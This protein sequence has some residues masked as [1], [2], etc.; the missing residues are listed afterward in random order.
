MIEVNTSFEALH[1]WTEAPNFLRHPHRHQFEV[2]VWVETIS[3]DL[4]RQL[5]FFEVKALIEAAVRHILPE[6]PITTTNGSF[7][8]LNMEFLSTE[9]LS[10]L[11]YKEI[12]NKLRL[13]G[14]KV[15]IRIMED[16][17]VGSVTDYQDE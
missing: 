5:E 7:S 16:G 15:K 11:L 8:I 4:S 13:T 10:D 17:Q 9:A 6:M 12:R 1:Q 3:G 14:Q 2:T